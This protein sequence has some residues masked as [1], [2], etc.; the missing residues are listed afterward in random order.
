[1]LK[2][3]DVLRENK[4]VFVRMDGL[5]QISCG[6]HYLRSYGSLEHIG[7]F[8]NT[9]DIAVISIDVNHLTF[10]CG[11]I[12]LEEMDLTGCYIFEN[13]ENCIVKNC[14]IGSNGFCE[15]SLTFKN[16]KNVVIEQCRFSFNGF[17]SI[18]LYDIFE[19]TIEKCRFND[20][21]NGAVFIDN[22]KV[23]IHDSNINNN[24]NGDC[25]MINNNSNACINDC[26]FMNCNEKIIVASSSQYIISNCI[27][28]TCKDSS[29]IDNGNCIG[30]VTSNFLK[31]IISS[32]FIINNHS[33]VQLNQN[34]VDTVENAVMMKDSAIVSTW[35]NEFSQISKTAIVSMSGCKLSMDNDTLTHIKNDGIEIKKAGKTKI[36]NCKFVNI[37]QIGISVINTQIV[38]HIND[39]YFNSCENIGIGAYMQS[40]VEL[41]GNNIMNIAN[42]AFVTSGKSS[43]KAIKNKIFKVGKAMIFYEFDGGCFIKDNKVIKCAHRDDGTTAMPRYF[44]N[45]SNFE[46]SHIFDIVIF[47]KLLKRGAK[48]YVPKPKYC[49]KCFAYKELVKLKCGHQ[50]LCK[51]CAYMVKSCPFCREKVNFYHIVSTYDTSEDNTCAICYDNK[52]DNVIVMPCGHKGFCRQCLESWFMEHKICPFC[53]HPNSKIVDTS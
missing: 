11:N 25:I 35:S 6:Y 43:F 14:N 37:D 36:K 5:F 41:S 1:M 19:S 45:N 53:R 31:N 50:I 23:T 40:Y 38:V 24:F 20:G 27:I 48:D 49:C 22:S 16:C 3:I 28:D 51:K 9:L 33:K 18:S 21:R 2:L 8:E 17:C 46:N 47:D 30:V 12:H 39:N 26:E 7:D 42:Y 34:K 44:Q 29:I 32:A 52:C 10:K 15:T 4:A 13:C